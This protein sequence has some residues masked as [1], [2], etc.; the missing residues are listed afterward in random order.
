[1]FRVD[2]DY[3]AS[4]RPSVV[5]ADI[6]FCHSDFWACTMSSISGYSPHVLSRN[7]GGGITNGL[8]V[9]LGAELAAELAAEL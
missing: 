8:G 5:R 7:F 2:Q 6:L 3:V 4:V 9:V 1:M